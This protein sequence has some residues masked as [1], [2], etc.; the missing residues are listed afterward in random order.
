MFKYETLEDQQE[1]WDKV[2]KKQKARLEEDHIKV[3]GKK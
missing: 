2:K 1:Y 3:Y